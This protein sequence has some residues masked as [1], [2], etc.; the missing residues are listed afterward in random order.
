MRVWRIGQRCGGTSGEGSMPE[1]G[2]DGKE[3]SDREEGQKW[4]GVRRPEERS[5]GGKGKGTSSSKVRKAG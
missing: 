2:R 5:R 3:S 1:V 4:E